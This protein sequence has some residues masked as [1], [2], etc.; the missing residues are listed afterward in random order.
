MLAVRLVATPPPAPWM[1]G[2]FF[3]QFRLDLRQ[4]IRWKVACSGCFW[5][6]HGGLPLC[7]NIW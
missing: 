7:A 1:H 6:G 5:G 4:H 3:G 2:P